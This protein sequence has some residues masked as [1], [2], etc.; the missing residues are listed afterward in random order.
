M[1]LKVETLLELLRSL[2]VYVQKLEQMRPASARVWET[3]LENYWAVL[4]GLQIAVQ[5]VLD[6]GTHILSAENLAS[7]ADYADVIVE[8]GRNR[9]IPLEF[10]EK[11]K[12]MA[13][14]R[15]LLVHGYIE[16]NPDRVFRLVHAD[17]EDFRRFS[18]YIYTYLQEK[19]LVS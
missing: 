3:N 2:E 8:L 18:T 7:P 5:H 14:F 19:G 10:A 6:I 1:A 15:N 13:G 12:N 11:I 4:H 17:L 16:L 9:I